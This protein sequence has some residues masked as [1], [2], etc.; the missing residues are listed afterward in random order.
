MS[1]N[2]K[3]QSNHYDKLKSQYNLLLEQEKHDS[4]L[5]LAKQMNAWALQNE[6]DSAFHYAVSLRFIG[7]CYDNL[8]IT[9]SAFNYWRNSI[10]VLKKQNRFYSLDAAYCYLNIGFLCYKIGDLKKAIDNYLTLIEIYKNVIGE[11][12]NDYCSALS[13]LGAFYRLLGNYEE[14]EKHLKQSINI[15]KKIFG[16]NS[17][18]YA[19]ILTNLSN[20]YADKNEYNIA[21][22]YCLKSLDI[23][24]KISGEESQDYIVSLN[25]LAGIYLELANYKVAELNYI[26]LLNIIKTK[27]GEENEDYARC[28]S[29]LGVLYNSIGNYKD[30]KQYLI[31]SLEIYKKTLGDRNYLYARNLMNIGSNLE[32]V[33]DFTSSEKY[34]KQALEI[35]K[36][37]LGE[38]HPEYANCLGNLGILYSQMSDY[39]SAEQYFKQ[40][41]QIHKNSVGEEHADYAVSLNNLGGLYSDIGDY[42][43][44]EPLFKKASEIY[45]NI[46]G[47]SHPKY[48]LSLYNFGRLQY[49]KKDYKSAEYN[50]KESIEIDKKIFGNNSSQFATG[51]NSLGVLYDEILDYKT[52][53][54]YYNQALN[55]YKISVGEQHPDYAVCLNNLGVMYLN[56]GDYNAAEP[57]LKQAM[58]I[59]K[60]IFGDD[61]SDYINSEISFANL[62][63]KSNHEQEAYLILNKNISKKTKEIANN[64]EWLTDNQKEAYWNTEKIFYEN[65]SWF[66]NEVYQKVPQA[67]GLNYNA[68]L[69]TKSKL[70][71][72][73][74]STENYYREIDELRQELIYR[75]RLLAKME[76]EGST[77]IDLINILR[78][79]SDSLDKRLTLSWP[80]YAQQKKNLSI[81]WSQVQENL[82][83]GE[84]AIEFVRYENENDSLIYYNALVLKKGDMYPTLIAL[85]K[86]KDLK[87]ITPM[88]GSGAYYPLLW[89]PLESVLL[90]V[91]TIY[92]S[93]IG[94]LYNVPFHSILISDVNKEYLMDRYTLHQLTSTRY[95]A[96]GLKQKEKNTLS[97]SITLVG[98]VNYNYLLQAK[99]ESENIKTNGFRNQ[100]ALGKLDYLPGTKTEVE[101]IATSVMLNN[102]NSKVFVNNDATEENIIKME[103]REAPSIL[104]L[105]THG[106]AFTEFDFKD[107]TISKNSLRYS[108]RYSNNSM[109]RSGL[110]LAGGNWAWTGSDT[111]TKLGA[112]QNGVLT[113][114]EVS[115]LNLRNT[116]LV[117]L[118]GCETGLGKIE[119][120]EGT[121]GLKRGF[122][123]AG[124]EQIIVSLWP[125]PDKETM[126]LM[127]LFYKDLTTSLNPIISFEKA[128]IAMRNKYPASPQKWAGFV[129][130]R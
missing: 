21:L 89:K 87:S 44:A 33:G 57:F 24:K 29:N 73:K 110:I 107:T 112:E 18:E 54:Q 117:V 34:Y 71:E 77:K 103:G 119:G 121:F 70:L 93:P 124:V 108:Y 35:Y 9:D 63:F 52:A 14:S 106:Y 2:L 15:R 80:E 28:L 111:L 58:Q 51:L 82:S 65:I 6:T 100:P 10:V 94:E 45:K 22:D 128:Q 66:A 95:L 62:L 78:Q 84:A 91:K 113:A 30:G 13:D 114:L 25:N 19:A 49:F 11:E 1:L 50:F 125:V 43:Y 130:I 102:W 16:E 79:E 39:K 31:K 115:Q 120:S 98:G 37:N 20:L 59:R 126:E 72:S 5:I 46:F 27:Q 129:L 67:V 96:M 127:T 118:S 8:K 7:E 123:L 88:F 68:V 85:C 47:K 26:K 86:E 60:N 105:A 40:A 99:E 83:E 41:L 36:N 53:E 122:K 97:R 92:Y 12:H 56:M 32:G 90:G 55:I 64:F 42:G 38:Q 81:T 4:A 104:H 17:L 23:I 74:I 48:A 61:H 116:K 101:Q 109:V 75:R 76:S 69:L 3:S